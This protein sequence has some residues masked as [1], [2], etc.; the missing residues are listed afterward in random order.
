MNTPT[1]EDRLQ[2]VEADEGHEAR[3]QDEAVS[4]T[5]LGKVSD[6]QGGVWGNKYDSGMGWQ[7][8]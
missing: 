5:E 2:A 1:N 7:F 3:P 8:Y 4:L 6:T